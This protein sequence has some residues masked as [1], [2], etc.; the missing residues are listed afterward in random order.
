M[1]QDLRGGNKHLW[2]AGGYII[3]SGHELVKQEA[4]EE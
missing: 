1:S 2:T 3:T 4:L